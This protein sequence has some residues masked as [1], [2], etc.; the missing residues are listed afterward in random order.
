MEKVKITSAMTGESLEGTLVT[1]VQSNGKAVLFIHGW[2]SNEFGYIH[3]AKA[4]AD[5]GYICFAF[6]LRG[7]G[8]SDGDI[9]KLTRQDFIN[10]VT[11][12]YDFLAKQNSVNPDEIGIVS[13]SFGGYLSALLTKR[14]QVR[15][16][17]LRAPANYPDNGFEDIPQNKY[18]YE[19]TSTEG[20]RKQ[21]L[22]HN[23]TEALRAIYQYIHL[24]N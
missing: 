10:D 17:A 3:R 4:L 5:I 8:G 21:K 6:S 22:D 19:S 9:R 11:D 7:H 20:W 24:R 12:A 2:R 14:R 1:P 16:L 18:P 15:W 23:A 13:A